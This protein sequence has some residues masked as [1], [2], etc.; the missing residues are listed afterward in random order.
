[1]SEDSFLTWPIRW[2]DIGKYQD[3]ESIYRGHRCAAWHLE[4]SLE[5]AC[6]RTYD[7]LGKAADMEK[8]C[9]VNLGADFT[10]I[11]PTFPMLRS[12]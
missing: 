9:F 6:K 4:T 5:R 12:L 3:D 11:Q 2:D 10:I 7:S 1:M 8:Y